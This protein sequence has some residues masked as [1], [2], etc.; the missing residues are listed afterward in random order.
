[1]FASFFSATM[2]G[3]RDGCSIVDAAR[4]L[5]LLQL[6]Q[7]GRHGCSNQ[8]T[9]VAADVDMHQAP[10]PGVGMALKQHDISACEMAQ[11]WLA[12]FTCGEHRG[13][14]VRGDFAKGRGRCGVRQHG[15]SWHH[16]QVDTKAVMRQ[17]RCPI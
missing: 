5:S 17:D 8:R 14:R 16:L 2:Q 4:S 11:L 7:Q 9:A 15:D 12:L 1:M 3:I 6:L 13:H 10:G